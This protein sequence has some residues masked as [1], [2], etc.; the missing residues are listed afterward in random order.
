MRLIVVDLVLTLLLWHNGHVNSVECF[1][2][3]MN[4][5]QSR[6]LATVENVTTVGRHVDATHLE[7]LRNVSYNK[8]R[9]KRKG[10]RNGSEIHSSENSD[11]NIRKYVIRKNVDNENG[12]NVQEKVDIAQR[13]VNRSGESLNTA[14]KNGN[15][16]L[17]RQR[18]G[19]NNKHDENGVMTCGPDADQ[20]YDWGWDVRF[21]ERV[22]PRDAKQEAPTTTD[23]SCWSCNEYDRSEPCVYTRCDYV[24]QYKADKSQSGFACVY[25]EIIAKNGDFYQRA[26]CAL[27][28][29][30]GFHACSQ[31]VYQPMVKKEYYIQNCRVCYSDGCNSIKQQYILNKDLPLYG[32]FFTAIWFLY[33]GVACCLAAGACV[34]IRTYFLYRKA[35]KSDNCC[36]HSSYSP[37]HRSESIICP[38]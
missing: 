10:R 35:T 17:S 25:Y 20:Y 9:I 12:T 26:D 33:L 38:Y 14:G 2:S 4:A 19:K 23:I 27:A 37:S 3:G 21:P 32:N 31:L 29:N 28:T 11:M 36:S 1:A 15:S 7:D 34:V 16:T 22:G 6:D 13:E 30:Y 5:T 24:I 8:R 18:R